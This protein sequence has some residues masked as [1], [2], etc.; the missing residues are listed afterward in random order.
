MRISN[1]K[2]KPWFFLAGCWTWVVVVTS[3]WWWWW[4]AVLVFVLAGWL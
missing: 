4:R 3:G 1:P 2:P